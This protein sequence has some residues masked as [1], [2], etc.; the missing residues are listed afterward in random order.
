MY[1]INDNF[2]GANFLTKM[3]NLGWMY[4]LFSDAFLL[5]FLLYISCSMDMETTAHNF[6]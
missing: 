2:I 1:I 5:F 4:T 6:V 3:N